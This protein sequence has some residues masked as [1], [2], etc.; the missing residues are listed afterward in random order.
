[1]L[2]LG[3]ATM[4]SAEAAAADVKQVAGGVVEKS[5]G[6]VS[7]VQSKWQE[8]ADEQDGEEDDDEPR[9]LVHL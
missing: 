5:K 8:L 7:T 6:L 4:R 3:Q 2:A 9:R 1:L